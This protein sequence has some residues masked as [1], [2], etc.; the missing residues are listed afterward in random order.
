LRSPIADELRYATADY[1][2]LALH[3]GPLHPIT[4]EAK[5][6]VVHLTAMLHSGMTI[7]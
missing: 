1:R 5:R 2:M 3:A 4:L 6:R 7:T